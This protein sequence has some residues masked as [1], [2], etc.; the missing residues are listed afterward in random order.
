MVSVEELQQFDLF[1]TVPVE[2]LQIVA[3]RVNKR[4]YR[5][6]EVVFRQGEPGDYFYVI[7]SGR[8]SV[9]RETAKGEALHLYYFSVHEAFGVRSMLLNEPRTSSVMC[10]ANGELILIDAA[11]FHLMV[12]AYPPLAKSLQIR[13]RWQ[14]RY[15]TQTFPER[16]F[17]DEVG[18]L[19][20]RRH[21]Y[22]FFESLIIPILL[23]LI[24]GGLLIAL[25]TS[26]PLI[27][28]VIIGVAFSLWGLW[29][30]EDWYNDYLMLTS[31]RVIFAERVVW[32]SRQRFESPVDQVQ[33]VTIDV[34]TIMHRLLGYKDMGIQTAS[35]VGTI[36][37][38]KAPHAEEIA[39]QIFLTRNKALTQSRQEEQQQIEEQLRR[40]LGIPSTPKAPSPA[41][42]VPSGEE[43]ATETGIAGRLR[44]VFPILGNALLYF[45]P[46]LEET[47]GGVIKWRRHWFVLISQTGILLIV[48]LGI[49]T[50]NVLAWIGVSAF[51]WL[52]S[53]GP[54]LALVV[55]FLTF[56]FWLWWQYEDW[57]NDYYMVTETQIIDYESFP[58]GI[59]AKNRAG[60]LDAIQRVWFDIPNTFHTLID[61]GD[62]FVDTP[63][64]EK[65]FSFITVYKPRE[66]QREVFRRLDAFQR[67]QLREQ[68]EQQGERFGTWLVAYNQLII[69]VV[70]PSLVAVDDVH[71]MSRYRTRMGS[72][73]IVWSRV[74]WAATYQLEEDIA[75]SFS[76]PERVYDG[77]GSMWRVKD[78]PPGIY[79]Y[80]VRAC[81][82]GQCGVWSEVQ[83]VLVTDNSDTD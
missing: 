37:F 44:E 50:I 28:L 54:A 31:R 40:Q 13:A 59:G 69:S 8:F 23:L 48:T 3:Q 60:T 58:L 16:L 32:F 22:V 68:T 57:R 51:V 25:S 39:R 42:T 46:M 30:F 43:G 34:T 18:I 10:S 38:T 52:R 35:F 26:L 83:A 15:L 45:V 53:P 74:G 72:Y 11:T 7:L 62:V 9:Y 81:N 17:P 56:L 14:S 71:G 80:R 78:R 63:G 2:I 19:V 61:M 33:D 20:L 27:I 67:R 6:G 75:P 70:S 76:Y 4:Y 36:R 1:R 55:L 77:N 41:Q 12:E 64:H 66:I 79:Y 82:L 47:R 21:I 29:L 24:L 5:R 65:A 73:R 49:A